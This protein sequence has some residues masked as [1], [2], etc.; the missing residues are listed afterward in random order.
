MPFK[1]YRARSPAKLKVRE[2]K[3][4]EAKKQK[5]QKK[6]ETRSGT[7]PDGSIHRGPGL[8]H[9]HLLPGKN[10]AQTRRVS[11]QVG[12]NLLN[13]TAQ[14]KRVNVLIGKHQLIGTP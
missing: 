5:I 6:R 1:N 8:L 2:E 13:R 14:T 12:E 4:E 11:V 7:P 3:T 10:G 9:P